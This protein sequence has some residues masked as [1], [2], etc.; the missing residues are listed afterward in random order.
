MFELRGFYQPRSG[1]RHDRTEFTANV[2]GIR[3]QDF[4]YLQIWFST[5]GERGSPIQPCTPQMPTW[6]NRQAAPLSPDVAAVRGDILYI[7]N[8]DWNPATALWAFAYNGSLGLRHASIGPAGRPVS[9][10]PAL[11][12]LF[13][14]TLLLGSSDDELT[15]MAAGLKSGMSVACF[16]PV[17]SDALHTRL[18]TALARAGAKIEERPVHIRDRDWM[19]GTATH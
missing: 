13:G 19:L 8:N 12:A 18:L 9:D 6:L 1:T 10:A 3:E 14:P 15:M 16:R 7:P 17:P 2:T 11:N 4:G 5:K